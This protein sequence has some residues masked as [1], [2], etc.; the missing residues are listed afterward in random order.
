MRPQRERPFP[1]A[2]STTP[3]TRASIPLAKSTT[4]ATRASIPHRQINN[5]R[6]AGVHSPS[7]FMERGGR[8]TGGEVKPPKEIGECP[9]EKKRNFS[10]LTCASQL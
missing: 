1:I 5:A 10:R 4:P 8:K 6:N 3:A 7:P 9:V 2:K